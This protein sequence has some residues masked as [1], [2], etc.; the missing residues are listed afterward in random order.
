MEKIPL[1][2]PFAGIQFKFPKIWI[3][4]IYLDQQKQPILSM[5]Q[6]GLDNLDLGKYLFNQ[7]IQSNE[8]RIETLKRFLPLVT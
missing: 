8:D 5:L 3:N 1:F 7:L 6:A 2:G 4:W